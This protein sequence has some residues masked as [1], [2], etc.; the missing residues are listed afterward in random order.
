MADEQDSAHKRAKV[1]VFWPDERDYAGFLAISADYMPP[2]VAEY[3]AKLL[4]RA[5][6]KGFTEAQFVKITGNADELARWCRDH[7]RPVDTDARADYA[8]KLIK[9]AIERR[10]KDRAG[11]R[12]NN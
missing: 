7:G 9:T 11:G 3:R 5:A 10:E 12:S 8:A 1:A 6:D 4:S 2:T